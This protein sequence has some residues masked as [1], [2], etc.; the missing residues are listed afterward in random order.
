MPKL[1]DQE[2]ALKLIACGLIK[3]EVINDKEF[4]YQISDILNKI[5][6][7]K[8]NELD[9]IYQESEIGKYNELVKYARKYGFLS[10]NKE[11]NIDKVLTIL[12]NKILNIK[13][14]TWD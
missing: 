3:Q 11:P 10:K 4:V 5:D 8:F 6:S 13:N 7:T 14:I 1:T 9:Y 2:N 12:R